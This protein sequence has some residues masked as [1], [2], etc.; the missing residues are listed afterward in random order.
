VTRTASEEPDTPLGEELARQLFG[1]PK[2]LRAAAVFV[3][4]LGIVPGL[5]A[6]PFL[7]LA[8]LLF[9]LS[10]SQERT[11]ARD[12]RRAETEPAEQP[13]LRKGP[14]FLPMVVP[15]S[16]EVSA[17]LEPLLE[18]RPGG[19][20]GDGAGIR[21]RT[22][23]IRETLFLELGAPLPAPRVRVNHALPNRHALVSL[24]EIPS[25]LV[26]IPTTLADPQV[27]ARI[28]GEALALLRARA[29]DFLGLSE[30][31]RLLDELEQVAP[32][33]VRNVVPKPV[34]L[35]A[36]ADILRR[37]IEERVSVR[38][39]RAVLEALAMVAATEKDPLTLAEFVRGQL[40][41][42]ITYRLTGGASQLGVLLLDPS[43]E[44]TIRRAVTRTASGAFLSLAPPAARD[45]VAAIKRG[46]S[47]APGAPG[48]GPRVILTQP[49]IR[50]FVR[51]LL[52]SELDGVEVISFAELLPE[53]A[54]KTVGRASL[55]SAGL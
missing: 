36:L 8:A 24:F 46:V 51:K 45:V 17:D 4:L 42:S 47:L 7:V 26:A 44:D 52:D 6:A 12:A 32:A 39:L 37:L 1:I 13:A 54:L 33:V 30:T 10:W 20:D 29:A 19:A 5:P 50:R 9:F 43:L 15:W 23:A 28:A 55:S 35:T 38:D 3:L 48:D 11:L 27:A 40:R 34:S 14:Q 41:R 16:V 21:S 22:L 18:D 31:Q 49:D 53:V 25:K 2:A